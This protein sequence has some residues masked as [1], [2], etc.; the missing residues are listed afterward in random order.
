MSVP[1]D[2]GMEPLASFSVSLAL[3]MTCASELDD[4]ATAIKLEYRSSIRKK[5]LRCLGWEHVAERESGSIYCLRV[6]RSVEFDWTWEG[7][8]AFRPSDAAD[9]SVERNSD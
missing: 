7:A 4:A 5:R 9:E 3:P 2:R 8:V 1:D 6:G